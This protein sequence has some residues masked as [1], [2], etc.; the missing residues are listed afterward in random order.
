[1]EMPVQTHSPLALQ[2]VQMLILPL[3]ASRAKGVWFG[4]WCRRVKDIQSAPEYFA[5]PK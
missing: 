3:T 5:E 1:M 2:Q 4:L